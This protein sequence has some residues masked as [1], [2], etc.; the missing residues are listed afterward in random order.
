MG[1]YQV[2]VNAYT[3]GRGNLLCTMAGY[4]SCHNWE[5]VIE[6]IGYE[7]ELDADNPIGSVFCTHG[8]G[9]MVD[10]DQVEK[11]M[12]IENSMKEL[13]PNKTLDN[14]QVTESDVTLDLKPSK[15][16]TD[17]WQE[18]KELEEI[19]TRTFGPLKQSVVYTK[20]RLGYE[21]NKA[22]TNNTQVSKEQ[23]RN[24]KRKISPKEYLLVDGYNIIFSWKE[25]NDL[26]KENMDAA[27]RKLMDI[28]SN[29]QGY[30]KCILILVFD[31][32]KV[33][34]GSGEVQRYHNIDVVYT[35]EAETADQYIEKVTHDIAKDNHVIV[36]TSDALEQLIILGKGAIRLSAND[37]KEEILQVNNTIRREYLEKYSNNK[38]YIGEQFND[39]VIDYMEEE[40]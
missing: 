36:A 40:K 3:R 18:D 26:A 14:A 25:L 31:A 35:K 2:E 4:Q 30:K 10:W 7:S 15:V 38:A 20:S 32:Y 19:F 1:G 6:R 33:K 21:K 34:G 39:D 5:E 9:F 27:R 11:Y 8:A 24:I 23:F 17:S 12:H 13:Y 22:V 28:L 16:K 37:L 29:Y